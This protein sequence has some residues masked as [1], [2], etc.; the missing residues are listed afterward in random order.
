[1]GEY[2]EGMIEQFPSEPDP[3]EFDIDPGDDTPDR[4][5]VRR[6]AKAIYIVIVLLVIAGLLM[7]FFPWERVDI[8]FDPP[9]RFPER[10]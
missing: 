6:L 9:F 1:M 3:H 7:M 8:P 2:P 10:A 5:W 4:P